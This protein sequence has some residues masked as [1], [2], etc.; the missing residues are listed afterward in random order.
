MEEDLKKLDELFDSIIDEI[1][2][3]E[4]AGTFRNPFAA[5]RPA[6]IEGLSE[7][8][9]LVTV[10]VAPDNM[11]ASCTVSVNSDKHKTF[12]ADDIMR[13]ASSA[14]VFCGID[15]KAVAEM[16]EK[17]TVNTPVIIASGNPSVPGSDGRLKLKVEVGTEKAPVTVVKDTEVCHV[18]MPQSGR[19]GMDVR[20]HVLPA[21]SGT[22]AEMELGEGLYKRGNRVYADCDGNFLMR[23]GKY[24][25]VNEKIYEGNVD[26][27]HGVIV[28]DGTVIINGNVLGRGVIRAGGSVIVHGNVTAAVIEAGKSITIDGRTTESSVSSGEGVL[29]GKDFISSTLVSEGSISA[30]II[31]DC[32]VKSVYSIDCVTGMGK[33]SGGEIYCAGDVNCI[34]VGVRDHIETRI[35]MGEHEEFNEEIQQLENQTAHIDKDILNITTQVNEIH[36]REKEGTATL[37]DKSFLDAAM[38]IRAQ[39]V[40]EKAPLTE[41]LKKLY[42]IV[43]CAEKATLTAKTMIYGG[44]M[45]KIGGFTQ[46]INADRPRTTVKSN[47]SAIVMI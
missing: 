8:M 14:G 32:T 31:Q 3:P 26:Q 33:I 15:E 34:L 23:D 4:K 25:V 44:T 41:R 43:K 9:F 40:L 16:A 46:I 39:R 35:I 1:I 27:T 22:S 24:C 11:S 20:G 47:G 21:K 2:H 12:R 17:Q 30:D 37:E 7:S 28:F 13:A 6:N 45:L 38:R 36:E 10:K 18:I 42:V 5:E 19:D 29:R